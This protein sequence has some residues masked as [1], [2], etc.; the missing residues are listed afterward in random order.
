LNR[1]KNPPIAKQRASI[2]QIS[3]IYPIFDASDMDIN[4]KW[5]EKKLS[6]ECIRKIL[7][8]ILSFQKMTWTEIRNNGSHSVNINGLISKAQKRLRE[9]ELE[10]IGEL[11]SIRLSG[12]ERLWAIKDSAIL[13]LLWWDPCH[14]V[15]PSEKKG[16]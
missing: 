11:Y 2:D 13:R 12:P 14:T 4:M 3:S 5:G 1:K 6:L 15:Y 9:L 8:T 16:S 10:D 7:V